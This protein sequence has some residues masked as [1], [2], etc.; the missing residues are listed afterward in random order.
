MDARKR[1]VR[2]LA[3]SGKRRGEVAVSLEISGPYLSQIAGGQRRPGLDVA[4]RIERIT[5]GAVRV[6]DWSAA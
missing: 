6:A 1:L 2:W 3:D 5:S 4:V